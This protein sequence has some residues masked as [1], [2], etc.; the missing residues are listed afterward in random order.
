MSEAAHAAPN[1]PL[2][3][4]LNLPGLLLPV[5]LTLRLRREHPFAAAKDEFPVAV[6]PVG[7]RGGSPRGSARSMPKSWPRAG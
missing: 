4:G 2:V 3:L 1:L 5:F 7:G 6:R